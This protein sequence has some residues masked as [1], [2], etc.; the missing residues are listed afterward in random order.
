[1]LTLN[2]FFV[3]GNVTVGQHIQT[4]TTNLPRY[5]ATFCAPGES[6][7]IYSQASLLLEQRVLKL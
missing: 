3:K 1:M 2:H 4:Q 7:S 6:K 5:L